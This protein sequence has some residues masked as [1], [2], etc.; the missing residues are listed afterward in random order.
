[1]ITKISISCY[2]SYIVYMSVLSSH[3]FL[4]MGS[5]PKFNFFVVGLTFLG[6]NSLDNVLN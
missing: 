5:G 6:K 1:M 3:I 4:E 2:L